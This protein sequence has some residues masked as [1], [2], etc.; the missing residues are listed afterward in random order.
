MN[1]LFLTQGKGLKVFYELMLIMK[2]SVEFDKVGFYIADSLY[3]R[4]FKKSFNEIDS[5]SFYL[6]KEWEI[7]KQSTTVSIDRGILERYENEIG[8]PYLWDALV[9]DRR[10]YMGKTHT[11]SQDYKPRFSHEEMLKILQ[12]TLKS[13]DDLFNQVRPDFIL[14]YEG[15]TI[16]QYLS[17]L[18]ANSR[19][20]PV[21]IIKPSRLRNYWNI[22]NNILEPSENLKNT[23]LSFLNGEMNNEVFQLSNECIME[24]K[25]THARYEGTVPVS[26]K[27]PNLPRGKYLIKSLMS[28]I[29]NE[30]SYRFGSL[31]YDNHCSGFVGTYFG[32][33]IKR[34][35][36]AKLTDI[37]FR[38]T[39][40]KSG[41]LSSLYYAYFPLHTEPEK[42]LLVLGKSYM[43][44]IEAVRLISRNL[45]VGMKLIVKEH[46]WNIGKRP[47]G[48][49]RKLLNIPNVEIA[50]SLLTSRELLLYAKLITAISGSISLEALI[51]GVPVITLGLT[52]WNFLPKSMMRY[53]NNPE[54]VGSEIRDLL[55]NYEYDKNVINSYVAA[56]IQES[57]PADYWTILLG[58]G[59]YKLDHSGI[60][61]DL[62]EEAIRNKKMIEFSNYILDRYRKI[63][64]LYDHDY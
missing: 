19:K 45:P 41:E 11:F 13:I 63:K 51:C 44:Q 48:Y 17:F 22:D 7:V 5:G 24:I 8:S 20:I 50:D 59:G 16:G 33:Y 12:V 15:V 36:R 29:R 56:V 49:Y 40:I 42:T 60:Y 10:I 28:V 62:D 55:N 46:P 37:Y 39:Y 31:K 26:N 25:D 27:P 52:P 14:F 23:Y 61:D 58:R 6:L 18:F 3:Y 4:N 35:L 64:S 1:A 43:N 57:S 9:S 30:F 2:K 47:L 38:S 21:L 32:R 53:C 54:L 34:P